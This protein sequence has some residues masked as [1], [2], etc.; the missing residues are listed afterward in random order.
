MSLL[1][2]RTVTMFTVTL[3]KYCSC[4]SFSPATETLTGVLGTEQAECCMLGMQ[5]IEDSLA[6]LKLRA[7]D[8]HLAESCE[9]LLAG[10]RQALRNCDS[11]Q[12]HLSPH[13]PLC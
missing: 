12:L 7:V 2:S 4:R 1:L 3:H 5:E 9:D 6:C 10:V 8:D 13:D 11:W